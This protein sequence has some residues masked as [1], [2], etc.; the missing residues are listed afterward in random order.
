MQFKLLIYMKTDVFID[1][2]R[3]GIVYEGIA[4]IIH[5]R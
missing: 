3:M 1:G 5:D 4:W 2:L